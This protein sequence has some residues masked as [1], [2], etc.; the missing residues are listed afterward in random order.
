MDCSPC[1]FS[2]LKLHYRIHIHETGEMKNACW[3]LKKLTFRGV[4]SETYDICILFLR[5]HSSAQFAD[6]TT[7]TSPLI[8]RLRVASLKHFN[9]L[10]RLASNRC[11]QMRRPPTATRRSI[12][13]ARNQK[14]DQSFFGRAGNR[15]LLEVCR[16]VRSTG[17]T[18][19]WNSCSRSVGLSPSTAEM[20]EMQEAP[21]C[22]KSTQD[23]GSNRRSSISAGANRVPLQPR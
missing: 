7:C 19:T 13:L 23:G 8:P 17:D 5:L 22:S 18:R 16:T 10:P 2:K 9:N 21:S 20:F 3:K 14:L 6:N 15:N 1:I 4:L 12:D 11:A